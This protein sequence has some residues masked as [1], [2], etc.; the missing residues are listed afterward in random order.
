MVAIRHREMRDTESVHPTL[1]WVSSRPISS[2]MPASAV[3]ILMG[4]TAPGT[5]VLLASAARDRT[6]APA[7]ALPGR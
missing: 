1:R 2:G 6:R 5:R 7:K 4:S 3:T